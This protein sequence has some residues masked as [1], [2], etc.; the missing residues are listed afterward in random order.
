[1]L[2]NTAVLLTSFAGQRPEF[3]LPDRGRY[4]SM[5][6]H[7]LLSYM[8]LLVHTCHKRGAPATSGMVALV[9]P[10]SDGDRD[11]DQATRDVIRR[12][13]ASVTLSLKNIVVFKNFIV[14]ICIS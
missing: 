9:L 14:V 7:F 10:P 12:V 8:R 6:R 11:D 3:V 2:R 5:E 4:V 1:M 13:S